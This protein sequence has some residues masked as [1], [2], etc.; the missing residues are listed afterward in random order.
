MIKERLK[1]ILAKATETDDS[2]CYVTS[3]DADAL[4][5]AIKALELW[6]KL[7]NKLTIMME[8][9]KRT[10]SN[11]ITEDG[12]YYDGLYAALKIVRQFMK[13]VEE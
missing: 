9:D 13:E 1:D 2:V 12:L 10:F 6:D 5:V 4:K 8:G 7:E 3:E 11:Q